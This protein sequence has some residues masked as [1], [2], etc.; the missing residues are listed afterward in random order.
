MARKSTIS[1]ETEN[2]K[3]S[4]S[5]TDSDT[6]ETSSDTSQ[7]D[8]DAPVV[9]EGEAEEVDPDD[10]SEAQTAETDGSDEGGTD[11][12]K[13]GPI[14][15]DDDSLPVSASVVAEEKRGS[16]MP[17]VGGGLI[18][19]A[20]GF[21]AANLMGLGIDTTSVETRLDEL[22]VDVAQI[23][24]FDA[25]PLSDRMDTL[26]TEIEALQV[27]QAA[28]GDAPETIMD[29][30]EALE[31]NMATGI[32]AISDRVGALEERVAE[33]QIEQETGPS[34]A[35]EVSDE[36]MANFQLELQQLT[37]D[38]KAQVEAAKA[39]ASEIEA[40]AAQAAAEAERKAAIAA[41][42]AAVEN[43]EGFADELVL[44]DAPPKALTSSATEGVATMGALQRTF[45]DAARTALAS[46]TE[47]PQDAS[48]GEKLT[49]FLKRQTNARS[50]APREGDSVD[51]ILSRAEASLLNGD[52]QAA[53]A[54]VSA[55]PD[56]ALEAMRPWQDQAQ[57]RLDALSALSEITAAE[58]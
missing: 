12:D 56:E 20:I 23:E 11:K 35:E 22:A 41:L 58:N 14:G 47:V 28:S 16:V 44:F 9:I 3:E 32:E 42:S 50:L 39:Q 18:A 31:S 53:V 48:A 37:E 6:A 5:T 17:S 13:V 29:R 19:G 2:S 8:G 52:L 45:P 15:D 38:A 49:A 1:K 46:T 51:A 30:I 54:E 36:E 27:A 21:I 55:L 10:Q 25:A 33:F 43:G 24:P 4:D 34:R 57:A 7:D 26:V 40:A